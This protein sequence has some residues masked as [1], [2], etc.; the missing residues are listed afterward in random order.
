[1]FIADVTNYEAYPSFSQKVSEIVGERGLNLLINNAGMIERIEGQMMG[2]PLE[3]LEAKV[4][5]NVM[6]TNTVAPLMLI[7]VIH[8]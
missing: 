2:V 1:M 4:V 6:E 7:K 5:S 8:L 3:K